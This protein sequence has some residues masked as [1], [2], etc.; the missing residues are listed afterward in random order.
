MKTVPTIASG[1]L[2]FEHHRTALGIGQARPRLSWTTLC[3][4]ESWVQREYEIEVSTS[5]QRQGVACRT[6]STDSVL[7][8][9]PV[10]VPALTSGERRFARVRV[11]GSSSTTPS[12]WSDWAWVEA[13]LLEPDDWTARAVS[14]PLD[15]QPGPPAGAPLFRRDFV[16]R[17]PIAAA[18]LYATAHGVYEIELNGSRVG[19][20][21]LAPGW[22]SYS[23]RLRYQTYDVTA[24]IAEGAN[25]VGAMVA[26]GWYRGK[27]GWHGGVAD[28]YGSRL[29]LIAQLEIRYADGTTEVIA[30]DEHWRCAHGPITST[31]LYEGEKYDARLE[32]RGWSSAEFDDSRWRAVETFAH[33]TT[34]LTAPT[35]PA[36]K[37]IESLRPVSVTLTSAQTMLFDFGQNISGRIRIRAQGSAGHTIRLRHAEVLDGDQL[38]LRPLRYATALDEYTFGGDGVEEWEPRFTTHGFRYAEITG[39]PGE[40]H[41]GD[42]E[43]LVCHTDMRRTGWFSCS[44][45]ALNQLHDNVVWSMRGNFADVPTDCPQRDERLGWTGDIQVFAPTASFLYDCAG[46]LT[47]WLADLAAEQRALGTVP[48]YVPW[49]PLTFELAPAAA[50]GD[51]AVLVPWVVYQRTGDLE[52]LRAQYQSMVSWVDQVAALAGEKHLWDTGFQFGDWLDPTAPPDRPADARTDRYLVATAYHARSAQV[53]SDIAGVLGH[54]DDQRHY[55]DLAAAVR[56]AFAAEY[57]APSGRISSDSQTAYALAL[58]FDLLPNGRTAPSCRCPTCSTRR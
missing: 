29:A 48:H 38:A 27:L 11:W 51:A 19:D 39:W 58:A 2:R 46:F 45:P 52:I 56:A 35:G 8:P 12:E 23:H 1:S 18:R 37:R 50:W 26:D 10:N 47:S 25:A 6:E 32:Q 22:T 55:G 17:A 21:V 9:W 28:V 54:G 43:A 57:V 36:V 5:A 31:G 41:D 44:D 34:L 49:V 40:F 15:L 7:V 4:D 16:V 13:G 20:D 53:L 3:D 42:I 14:P 24:L 33:D 30:T